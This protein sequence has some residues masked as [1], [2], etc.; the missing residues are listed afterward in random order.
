[1]AEPGRQTVPGIVFHRLHLGGRAESVGHPLGRALIIGREAH[2]D[3]AIVENRVVGAVG[4]LDLVQR[5]GDEEAL[6]PYPAMK[7]SALSKKSR[8]PSAGN[9]SSIRSS[10]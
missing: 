9:S 5:L 10:R 2:P 6:Q 1:M 3:V 7:A 8:R 4:L